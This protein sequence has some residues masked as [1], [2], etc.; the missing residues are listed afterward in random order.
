MAWHKM[1]FVFGLLLAFAVVAT[2][3]QFASAAASGGRFALVIGNAKYP[4]SEAPLKDAINDA[5]EMAKE[6][7]RDGFDVEIGENLTKNAMRKALDG[8][9]GKIKSGSVALIFFSGFG[10]QSDR[11]SYL[12]PVNAQVWSEADVRR[13]GFSIDTVLKEMSQRGAKIKI[14]ILNASR[15][16]PYERRFR[17]VSQGLAP[18]IAPSNSIVMYSTALGTVDSEPASSNQSMFMTELI[19]Q[20][21]TPGLSGEEVFIR[22]RFSLTRASGGKQTPWLSSSLAEKF[23]FDP[24]AASDS[25]SAVATTT[26]LPESESG[27]PPSATSPQSKSTFPPSSQ[28]PGAKPAPAEPEPNNAPTLASDPNEK[29][30]RDYQHAEQ[31]GTRRSWNDFLDMHPNGQYAT[32]A[33]E[34]LDKLAKLESPPVVGKPPEPGKSIPIGKSPEIP[35]KKSAKD[36]EAIL[37]LSRQIDKNPS[38]TDAYYKRGILYAKNNDYALATKDFDAVIR[39][40]PENPDAL[41]NRCWARA[42]LDEIQAALRDCDAALR[43]RPRFANAFDSRGLLKLKSGQPTDALHD[44]NASLQINGRQASSLYGRG[45]A[46]IRSGNAAGGRKDIAAAKAIDPKIGEEF[47]K[48]GIR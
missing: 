46:K 23:Y 2:T 24:N 17:S 41:N 3:G 33:K 39:A 42:M 34:K 28:F 36:D 32:L 44:Y 29:A 6:L 35:V 37:A 9:Y 45:I 38:D 11:Q 20:M 1:R 43:L 21:R 26:N 22:T 31:I 5:R 12:I 27:F 8:L 25:S 47:A 16:N 19:K 14:A 13:D 40:R 48:Y 10:L 30:R 4:D 15:R 7:R 18:V